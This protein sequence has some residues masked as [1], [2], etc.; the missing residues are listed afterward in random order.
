MD[1][2][3]TY[4]TADKWED[5]LINPGGHAADEQSPSEIEDKPPEDTRS[6]KQR[7]K[8]ED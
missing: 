4:L 3:K 2:A 6:P 8:D 5:P 1:K 7:T